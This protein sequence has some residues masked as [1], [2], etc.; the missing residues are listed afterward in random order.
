MKNRRQ[1]I[2]Q[3]TGGA[4]L[5]GLAGHRLF[6]NGMTNMMDID[7]PQRP[8]FM[9]AFGS[10]CD[11]TKPQ[12]FW[13][14]LVD[15]NPDLW[16]WLGDSIYADYF[17]YTA[18]RAAYETLKNRPGYRKLAER[19]QIIGTWD[20]HDFGYNNAGSE[21]TDKLLSKKAYLEFLD[22]PHSSPRW[23]REGIYGSHI[24]EA[25]GQ[26]ILTIL[27]DL[28]YFKPNRGDDADLLGTAQWHWLE[29]ELASHSADLILIGSSIQ[30]IPDFTEKESWYQYPSSRRRLLE[31]LDNVDVPT[32]ILSGDRHFTEFSRMETENKRSIVEFTA[33]GLTHTSSRRN[34]NSFR[35]G[36]VVREMNFGVIEV[37][38]K[39][40]M[41]VKLRMMS[42]VSGREINSL[43]I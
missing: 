20:D 27:L 14:H 32:I 11:Q 2:K 8:D 12:T 4:A 41:D 17:P 3:M 25:Q 5:L 42:A 10:C 6:A 30:C 13:N 34:T 38:F 39:P 33:S 37:K 22:E 1:F 43:K 36:D 24:L 29:N 18:R 28:R 31:L 9:I 23:N 26:R 35:V 15:L 19:C 16:I 40:D 7:N 21:F